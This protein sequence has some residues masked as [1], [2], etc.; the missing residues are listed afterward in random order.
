MAELENNAYQ[1]NVA[2]KHVA[3]LTDFLEGVQ[4]RYGMGKQGTRNAFDPYTRTNSVK[5]QSLGQALNNIQQLR[6]ADE[7]EE[8]LDDI[9]DVDVDA[10]EAPEEDPESETDLDVDQPEDEQDVA[11]DAPETEVSD[12]DVDNEV[13]PEEG[14]IVDSDGETVGDI[15]IG[16]GQRYFMGASTDPQMVIVG[17]VSE[18]YVWFYSFPFKKSEKIKK[19]IAADL[20]ST[21]SNTWLK[22]PK[23]KTDE[24]LKSSIESVL[25]DRPGERVSVDDYQFSN[26]QVK[27]TGEDSGDLEPWKELESEFDVVVDSNLTNKQTYN[28]RM[29][30][31]ELENFRATI[32]EKPV[33]E[34]NFK[35]IRIV[36]EERQYMLESVNGLP[37]PKPN[38]RE[39]EEFEKEDYGH[40][41]TRNIAA[42]FGAEGF[43][44][45]ERV[46]FDKEEWTV[47]DFIPLGEKMTVIL[48]DDAHENIHE[49][50]DTSK[51]K[52][53]EE[54]KS[55]KKPKGY[56]GKQV[57]GK[58]VDDTPKEKEIKFP[59]SDIKTGETQE[60]K[61]LKEETDDT[62]KKAGALVE[63]IN[64]DPE[65]NK[66]RFA[67]A[68][69][70]LQRKRREGI[71]D[72]NL[73]AKA[74]QVL[75]DEGARKYF[76]DNDGELLG[77]EYT[78]HQEMFPRDVRD[79]VGKTF[80]KQFEA[81][82]EMGNLD[83]SIDMQIAMLVEQAEKLNEQ[84]AEAIPFTS[85]EVNE[86]K[87]FDNA[88]TSAENVVT[89]TWDT[90]N[91][92]FK[93]AITKKPRA[94]TNDFVYAAVS[95]TGGNEDIDDERTKDSESFKTQEDIPILRD[96]LTNLN[97]NE[98]TE[99]DVD[100]TGL[101]DKKGTDEGD[102][103]PEQLLMGIKV[104]MEHTKDKS[105]AKQ[106]ALDHL[107]EVPDYYTRLVKMEKDTKDSEVKEETDRTNPD[108]KKPAHT[109]TKLVNALPIRNK[110]KIRS[111]VV[112][113]VR[114]RYKTFE[115]KR[116]EDAER[117]KKSKTKG[118]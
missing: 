70:N 84:D 76:N 9:G 106:I 28:L 72:S 65:L 21:G 44:S 57:D 34:R 81:N 109:N 25:N 52:K 89:Y 61:A 62:A 80:L 41:L 32:Q 101:A 45:G 58:P 78:S 98:V 26:I 50:I 60:Q 31:K 59:E 115:E 71:Y 64:Q 74:F 104:E 75:I 27:Y 114:I 87:K 56:C 94:E 51:L 24:D 23:S 108:G 117:K 86:I 46:L 8:E 63:F 18:D 39:L 118:D 82:V 99:E 83:E 105:L 14:K 19:D 49:Y 7:D 95:T 36:T 112:G 110:K 97:L 1:D 113:D 17:K 69:K 16:P 54:K 40:T 43:V 68:V 73:A 92:S 5:E 37:M 33:A 91:Q 38:K 42:G 48:I 102:V 53:I 103:H 12:A 6:E 3:P 66:N 88:E 55:E 93:V 100:T 15:F 29:N 13:D 47:V 111:E 90:G 85:R 79:D 77:V 35:I 11:V 30:N 4:S 116:K 2:K 20:F 10:D 22:D 96:F 67:P 107:T